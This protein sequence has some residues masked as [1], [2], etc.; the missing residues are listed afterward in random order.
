MQKGLLQ[1]EQIGFPRSIDR[2]FGNKDY[3]SEIVSTEMTVRL[4][5]ASWVAREPENSSMA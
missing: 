4:I 1:A 2:S 3:G 5:A